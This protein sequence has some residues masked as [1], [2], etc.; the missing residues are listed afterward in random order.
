MPS[1]PCDAIKLDGGIPIAR[2]FD[3]ATIDIKRIGDLLNTFKPNI[4]SLIK[5][6]WSGTQSL[7]RHKEKK[8]PA[9]N[10]ST[11]AIGI[12]F[13]IDPKDPPTAILNIRS[14]RAVKNQSPFA[15]DQSLKS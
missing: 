6:D 8:L 2:A 4:P 9:I 11:P 12:D 10:K 5:G 13:V 15:R 7:I 14:I 3:S 1:K